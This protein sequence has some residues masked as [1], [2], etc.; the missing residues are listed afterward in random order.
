MQISKSFFAT[1]IL[2]FVSLTAH[3]SETITVEPDQNSYHH[4]SHYNV[5][6]E[7]P[8]NAVWPHLIDLGSWMYDFEMSVVSGQAGEEGAVYRLY[9]EQ[10]FLIQVT[11]VVPNNLLVIA[12]LPSTFQGESSTGVGV[13][14]LNEVDGV[15]YVDLTMSRRYS[16]PGEGVNVMKQQRTSRDFKENSRAMWQGRF[17]GKLKALAQ[18]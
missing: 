10:G 4:V 9:P 2:L 17:L 7:A 12:N 18:Q 6:I 14:R 16:W 11:S 13:I 8:A 15:T 5:A 3:A 1:T